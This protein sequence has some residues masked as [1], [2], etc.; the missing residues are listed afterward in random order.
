MTNVGALRSLLADPAVRAGHLHTELVA[1]RLKYQPVGD[2]RVLLAA[3][4]VE[5]A[6]LGVG[7][8]WRLGG[9]RAPSWWL[10]QVEDS[11][12]VDV[13]LPAGAVPEPGWEHARDGHTLWLGKDGYVWR[14][15][16]PEIEE[17][18]QEVAEGTVRAPMPGSVLLLNAKVGDAV[19][20]GET[21][22]VLESMKMEL[23][24]QAPFDGTVESIDVAQGDTV[25]QGQTLVVVA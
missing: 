20:E 8:G 22:A 3:A 17:T 24:L 18:R 23:S 2:E 7:D 13:E 12:A 16:E 1:Q 4:A 15:R 10:L 11:G 5:F 6:E 19:T 9:V 21:L 25:K 14:V